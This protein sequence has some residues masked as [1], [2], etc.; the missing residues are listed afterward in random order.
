MPILAGLFVS[1]MNGLITF[2]GYFMSTQLAIQWGRRV[3]IIA[4]MAAFF[5]AV[6]VCVSSLLGAVSSGVGG[7][8]GGGGGGDLLG[9]FA[10]GVGMFIPSNAGP[11]LACLGSVWVACVVYR[12]KVDGLRW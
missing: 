2:F 8:G 1:A 6:K 5:V 12:L 7:G 9:W 11:V 10:M 3:F 4:V